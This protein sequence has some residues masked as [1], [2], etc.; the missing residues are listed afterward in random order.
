MK[1]AKRTVWVANHFDDFRLS[2][3]SNLPVDSFAQIDPASNKLPPPALV[4][5]AM[6]PK[7]LSGKG[8]VRGDA[9]SDEASRRMRVHGQKEWD[10]QMMRIP[11]SLVTLLSN[12]GV[13]SRI[14]EQHT[15]QHNM[16]GNASSLLV[17]DLH[18]CLW[19]DLPSLYV[20]EVD[21]VRSGVDYRPNQ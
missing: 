2:S 8:G 5:N 6:A 12:L 7:W 10:E 13:C 14:H 20:E 4:S 17:M 3:C 1:Q 11:E 18:C 9:I 21:V 16:P 15:Q 19:S